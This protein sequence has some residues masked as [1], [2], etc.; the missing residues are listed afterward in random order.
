M[1]N[2]HLYYRKDTHLIDNPEASY[3]VKVVTTLTDHLR[4]KGYNVYTDRFYTSPL[5]AD[6]LEQMGITITG[7]VLSNKQGLP[8][9]IKTKQKMSKG[10]TESYR[11]AYMMALAW[12]DKKQF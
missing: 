11:C 7:T 10:T 1:H 9:E 12:Q 3:I 6:A 4:D 5:L 2:L 8:V